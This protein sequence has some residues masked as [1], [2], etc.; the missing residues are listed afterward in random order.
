M[1]FTHFFFLMIR[2]PPRSTLFP[3]TTLFR[4]RR[5]VVYLCVQ[6]R[7]PRGVA[8]ITHNTERRARRDRLVGRER[9]DR[10]LV[11]EVAEE[12]EVPEAVGIGAVEPDEVAI[13]RQVDDVVDRPAVVPGWGCRAAYPV[14]HSCVDGVRRARADRGDL[15]CERRVDP[16]Q[17]AAP[18]RIDVNP[19]VGALRRCVPVVPG[20]DLSLPVGVPV[21]LHGRHVGAVEERED[22]WDRPAVRIYERR[23]PGGLR[24]AGQ[25][26]GTGRGTRA[27]LQEPA[28]AD[29]GVPS[30]FLSIMTVTPNRVHSFLHRLCSSFHHTASLF[31]LRVRDHFHLHYDIRRSGRAIHRLR[32]L[33]ITRSA[34]ILASGTSTIASPYFPLARG[35]GKLLQCV[36]GCEGDP[37]RWRSWSLCMEGAIGKG[38]EDQPHTEYRAQSEAAQGK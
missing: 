35:N 38:R 23:G 32:P 30:P 18:G 28:T 17:L 5:R 11:L 19:V 24:K 13:Q 2:R 6:L 3:Y 4:S 10:R 1:I 34:T 9:L 33:S 25:Q 36:R 8:R 14:G 37:M 27:Q 16:G 15:A 12:H 7:G 22:E 29:P 20:V 26:K 31:Y 21:I